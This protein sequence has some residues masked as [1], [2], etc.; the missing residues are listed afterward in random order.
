MLNCDIIQ[1]KEK[2]PNLRPTTMKVYISPIFQTNIIAGKFPL[3]KRKKIAEEND[4][5]K[6]NVRHRRIIFFPNFFN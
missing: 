6:G 5:M 1:I 2:M 4:L 3:E